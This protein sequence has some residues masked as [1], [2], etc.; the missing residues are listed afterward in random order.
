M[1]ELY[2]REEI[3]EGFRRWIN[4]TKGS[5]KPAENNPVDA[6]GILIGYIEEARNENK[7]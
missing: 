4:D 3:E 5:D 7:D 6:T 1:P 2:T